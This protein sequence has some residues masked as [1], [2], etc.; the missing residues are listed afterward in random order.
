MDDPKSAPLNTREFVV[1]WHATVDEHLVTKLAD[2]LGQLAAM[3]PA[4]S[5]L[6][7]AQYRTVAQQIVLALHVAA[8]SSGG[9]PEA[10]DYLVQV[11]AEVAGA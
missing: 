10:V 2:S 8:D 7:P 9:V 5:A 6:Q 1:R 4:A 3:Q 11:A